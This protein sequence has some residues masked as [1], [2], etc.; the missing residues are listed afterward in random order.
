M[1]MDSMEY[2]TQGDPQCDCFTQNTRYF[3]LLH[4]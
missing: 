3:T 4:M 1:G 2:V